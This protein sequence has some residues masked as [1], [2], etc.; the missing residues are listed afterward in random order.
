[1]NFLWRRIRKWFRERSSNHEEDQS[2]T[3]S[4]GSETRSDHPTAYKAWIPFAENIH[5]TEGIKMRSRGE[6]DEGYPE[7]LIVHWT[8]GWALK[9]G[10]WPSPF[11]SVTPS[12]RRR[13]LDAM[14]REYALRT[15]EGAVKNG[16][17]F[18]VMDVFGNIYQSRPLTKHGYHAGKSYY[19]GAG[20]NVSNKL[21]GIEI[22]N[23][24]KL[25]YKDGRFETW[26]G[27]EIPSQYVRE[28]EFDHHNIERGS[29]CVYTQEQEIALS[30]LVLWL[31][32]NSPIME[33][34]RRVFQP[35]HILGHDEVSPGRKSDPGA[36]LSTSMKEFRINIFGE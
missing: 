33:S 19:P 21:G 14:A 32:D 25:K 5:E 17:L 28:Q 29:Y 1:M 8:S 31:W 26:F 15:A 3:M 6:Y 23:P 13:N 24:G 27:L 10:S 35:T 7:G 18:L 36:S 9:R 11:P 22:L 30:K 16:Y 4:D 20:Y 2:R 12:S 34:G